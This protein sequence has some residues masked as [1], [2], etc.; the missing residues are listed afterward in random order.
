MKRGQ[1]DERRPISGR[2]GEHWKEREER[3]GGRREAKVTEKARQ[4]QRE[5]RRGLAQ[6]GDRRGP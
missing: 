2:G 3:E 4:T 6:S 1:T 5:T